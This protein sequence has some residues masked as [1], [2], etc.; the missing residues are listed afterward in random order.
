M[1]SNIKIGKAFLNFS[2][3]YSGQNCGKLDCFWVL[4]IMFIVVGILEDLNKW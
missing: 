3:N 1:K 2:L 4:G